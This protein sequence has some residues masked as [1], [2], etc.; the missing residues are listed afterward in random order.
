[1]L[2][3]SLLTGVARVITIARQDFTPVCTFQ[4]SSECRVPSLTLSNGFDEFCNPEGSISHTY[5]TASLP[6]YA[7]IMGDLA[8]TG[9][10]ADI[11][12]H[13]REIGD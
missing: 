8:R 13:Q 9:S 10:E 6:S 11:L 3:Y 12:L 7:S 4:E 5:S 1:M 2:A